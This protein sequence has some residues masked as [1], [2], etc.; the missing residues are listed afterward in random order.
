MKK[1]TKKIITEYDPRLDEGLTEEDLLDMLPDDEDED[2]DYDEDDDE[3]HDE[4]EDDDRK[5][6]KED[7]DRKE[8]KEDD[9][10][11]RDDKPD[12]PEPEP[13][14]GPEGG[15]GL[16]E[17]AEGAGEAGEIAGEGAEAAELTGEAGE[18]GGL[19]VEGTEGVGC[20]SQFADPIF[21]G[22]IAIL[23]VFAVIGL[24]VVAFIILNWK[25]PPAAGSTLPTGTTTICIDPG[26]P[27]EVGEGSSYKSPTLTVEEPEIVFGVATKLKSKLEKKG[28]KVVLTKDSARK[29]MTNIDRAKACSKAGAALM[30]RIHTNDAPGKEGP[31]HI[32]PS[33]RDSNIHDASKKHAETIH[34]Q[35]IKYLK[36]TG[37][38][39]PKDS[40]SSNQEQPVD[41]GTCEEGS[42]NG[43]S[44]L[45]KGSAQ[46]N[47]DNLPAV[48]IEMVRLDQQGA[49][50][51]SNDSNQE[52]IAEGIA[53]GIFEAV[54]PGS[55]SGTTAKV[56]EV[57]YAEFKKNV[58]EDNGDNNT[59]PNIAK[60]QNFAGC[61]SG[62]AWCAAFVSWVYHEAGFKNGPR[63]CL[64]KTVAYFFDNAPHKL[65][66]SDYQSGKVIPQPGDIVWYGKSDGIHGH[67]GIVYKVQGT[68]LTTIEG[69]SGN[70]LSMNEY[71]NYGTGHWDVL[72]RW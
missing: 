13:E 30:Y 11:R 36:S 31:F 56:A 65:Y 45:L 35:L 61:G 67:I 42:G 44:G 68:K 6:R 18:A 38:P 32:Y 72:G 9:D 29:Y 47:A 21:Y 46:A 19:I 48:L 27:S 55:G 3:Y 58:H 50:W 64:S 17:G 71:S 57:A 49:E 15:E 66:K 62:D 23:I 4:D 63:D 53:G 2:E 26:H 25:I 52:K 7:D 8:R 54:P 40:M 69:N 22:I 5:E 1:T 24:I 34:A 12:E 10:R 43:C 59:D 16:G 41:G 60:Y 33:S 20:L 70:A 37:L 51:I 14:P 28:Y 39:V